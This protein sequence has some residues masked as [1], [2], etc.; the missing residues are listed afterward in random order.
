[1]KK[2]LKILAMATVVTAAGA[3]PMATSAS[4]V[5]AS[6]VYTTLNGTTA[7]VV[8]VYYKCTRKGCGYFFYRKYGT[9]V[10]Y[11]YPSLFGFPFFGPVVSTTATP[12]SILTLGFL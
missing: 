5:Q 7:A 1:M 8:P 3:A 2:A 11:T 10:T 12:A 9:P 6:A 4:A